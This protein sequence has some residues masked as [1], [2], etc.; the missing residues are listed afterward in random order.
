MGDFTAGQIEIAKKSCS[1]I[2]DLSSIGVK[3]LDTTSSNLKLFGERLISLGYDIQEFIFSLQDIGTDN[4]AQSIEK[5]NDIVT[6]A[7]NVASVSIDSLSTFTN[8]LI[9]VAENG[10]KG[11]CKHFQV[12][13]Q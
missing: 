6:M 4:I 13:N 10:V 3:D 5:V 2:N 7:T 8:S 1:V 9:K 12:M 11:F